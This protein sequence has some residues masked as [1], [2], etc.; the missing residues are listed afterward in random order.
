MKKVNRP[1]QRVAAE[2]AQRILA[3]HLKLLLEKFQPL[4]SILK[5]LELEE[6]CEE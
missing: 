2:D 5:K 4:G 3:E 6:S 1:P